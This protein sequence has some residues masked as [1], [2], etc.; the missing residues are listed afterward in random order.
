MALQPS[1]SWFLLRDRTASAG[2]LHHLASRAAAARLYFLGS[3]ICPAESLLRFN[4][5]QK[6][7]NGQTTRSVLLQQ[8]TYRGC[9]RR[10]PTVHVWLLVPAL[11]DTFWV[12]S[13]YEPLGSSHITTVMAEIN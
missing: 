10:L 12:R 11:R 3:S 1:T 9:V 4:Q 5:P 8:A 7:C 13:T 6:Y 2:F